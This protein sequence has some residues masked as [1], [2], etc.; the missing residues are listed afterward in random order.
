MALSKRRQHRGTQ[1]RRRKSTLLDMIP[2]A[3]A[4]FDNTLAVV[5]SAGRVV[6]ATS[7][8]RDAPEWKG[9]AKN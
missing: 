8:C 9:L 5:L 2:V 1:S 3:H 7:N 6:A 4:R